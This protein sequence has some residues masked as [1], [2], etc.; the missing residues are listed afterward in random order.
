[1]ENP[2]SANHHTYPESDDVAQA[3]VGSSSG[4][5]A[6][7]ALYAHVDGSQSQ[8]SGSGILVLSVAVTC[9]KRRSGWFGAFGFGIACGTPSRES[10][11]ASAR[12]GAGRSS[13]HLT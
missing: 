4:A 10:V 12:Q 13:L 2:N 9:R 6:C 5:P 8:R 1:V 3:I 7:R 11:V